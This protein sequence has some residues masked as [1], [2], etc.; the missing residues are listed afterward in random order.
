MRQTFEEAVYSMMH[1][2]SERQQREIYGHFVYESG[3]AASEIGFWLLDPGKASHVDESKV[4]CPILV[5]AGAED[6]ITPASVVRKVAAKYGAV[7][8]YKEFEGHSHWVVGEPGWEDIAQ[9]I[10]DWL[11]SET[12][13]P[14][15]QADS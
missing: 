4:T 2:L 13:K 14:H 12:G 3:R 11:Q 9:Y 5:I 10:Y 7:S 1:L 8:T 6:R 15:E